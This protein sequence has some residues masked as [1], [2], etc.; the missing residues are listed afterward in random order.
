MKLVIIPGAYSSHI[1]WTYFSQEM[2]TN[3]EQIF[4]DYNPENPLEETIDKFEKQINLI[5]D[6]IILA[7]HSLGGIIALN[8]AK[9]C[10]NIKQVITV[11]SPFGGCM[12]SRWM[13]F[14]SAVLTPMNC[15]WHNTHPDTMLLARLR[16]N[17]PTIKTTI[18]VVETQN[19]TMWLEPSD[20]IV[21]VGS[22]K[23][24]GNASNITYKYVYGT[25]ADVMLHPDFIEEVKSILP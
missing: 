23:A 20:G 21:T 15:L 25:H 1:S 16:S 3:I 7:A 24:L 5:D 10:A 6:E 18:F 19:S 4:L 12:I 14:I 11:A 13:V 9:R 17:V 8:L 2:P 22:Q